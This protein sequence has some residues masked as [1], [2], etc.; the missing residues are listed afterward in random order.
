[1]F[2]DTKLINNYINIYKTNKNDK[3]YF[4]VPLCILYQV[5][6]KAPFGRVTP[7]FSKSDVQVL[8]RK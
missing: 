4:T 6:K 5:Q 8:L 3:K 7:R 1:M 2:N